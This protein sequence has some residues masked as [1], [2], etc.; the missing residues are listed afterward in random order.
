MSR[1]FERFVPPETLFRGLLNMSVQAVWIFCFVCLV[2]LV[3]RRAPKSYSYAMWSAMLFRLLCPIRFQS[4]F[5]LFAL[6]KAPQ[7]PISQDFGAAA[8][9][10]VPPAG[11]TMVQATGAAV[12]DVT[13][14]TTVITPTVQQDVLTWMEVLSAVWLVGV[15]L[16]AGYGAVSLWRLQRSL[17]R[18]Q[19]NVVENDGMRAAGGVQMYRVAGLETAFVIGLLQP[20][21]Y[22]PANL[23]AE[24]ERYIL[25]HELTHLRRGDPLWRALAYLALCLHWF[26]PFVW[27]AFSLSGRDMEMSCDEAVVRRYGPGIKKAYS[28]SL[29]SL[30]TGRRITLAAPLAFGEGDT[31]R[32]I[33]NVLRYKKPAVWLAA[34]AGVLVAVLCLFMAADPKDTPEG[35][36][37][38][39]MTNALADETGASYTICFDLPEKWLYTSGLTDTMPQ[40]GTEAVAAVLKDREENSIGEVYVGRF[41]VPAP[42]EL[43]PMDSPNRH[44]VAYNSFML[45][46]LADWNSEYEVVQATEQT[47]AATTTFYVDAAYGDGLA[48]A[49]TM[50]VGGHAALYF[51]LEIGAYIKVV[52]PA[53]S[54]EKDAL[55]ALAKSLAFRVEQTKETQLQ[56]SAVPAAKEAVWHADLNNDG[57]DEVITMDAEKLH[58]NGSASLHISTADGQLLKEFVGISTSHAGWSTFAVFHNGTQ[59]YLMEYHPYQAVGVGTYS[60]TLWYLNEDGVLAKNEEW[61]CE[62][63]MGMPYNAPDNDVHFMESFVESANQ[64]WADSRL[65]FTTDAEVL[66][67]LYK[68][69][70]TRYDPA[71]GSAYLL[72]Q[73]QEEA[74]HYVEIMDWVDG[75]LTEAR[76]KHGKPYPAGS[77]ALWEKLE[78][79]NAVFADRRAEAA[80]G[81]S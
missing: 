80:Q 65:L 58:S 31:S 67:H 35:T 17:K 59:A 70:E 60:Y 30:A 2:R 51:D 62:F 8:L 4:V 56:S 22:L 68:A 41:T 54:A 57:T 48:D 46:N 78:A 75:F 5:S 66:Q 9:L 14:N 1:V 6:L 63:S 39:Q 19:P 12:P 32:R 81:N 7:N 20:R 42:E 28:A 18:A 74:L 38:L 61:V 44:M 21:V 77:G 73:E 52:L 23:T 24:Q 47:E 64:I 26:N 50:A 33:K 55:P 15:V 37:S 25:A 34:V 45:G 16:M 72:V 69:D 3:L 27:A 13:V 43:P 36:G 40:P 79:V 11:Q 53:D 49:G 29:L 10:P 76:Q 71:A